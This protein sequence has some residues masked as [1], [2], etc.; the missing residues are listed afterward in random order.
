[1]SKTHPTPWRI[2]SK[3]PRNIYDAND[4]GIIMLGDEETAKMIVEAVNAEPKEYWARD[5]A[6]IVRDL[7][8]LDPKIFCESV[9][10]TKKLLRDKRISELEEQVAKYKPYYDA[11]YK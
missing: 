3:V 5:P 10:Q 2:G 8:L 1:M 9:E 7:V 6:V 11:Y 4:V